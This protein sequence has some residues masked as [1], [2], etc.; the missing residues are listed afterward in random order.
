MDDSGK[1][2]ASPSGKDGDSVRI[3]THGSGG[4]GSALAYQLLA[5]VLVTGAIGYLVLAGPGRNSP[6]D[7]GTTSTTPPKTQTDAADVRG[8]AAAAITTGAGQLTP[9][10]TPP[11]RDRDDLS[12]YVAPGQA[13]TMAEVIQRLNDAGIHTGLGA[14]NPPGTSPPLIG[15]AVPDDYVMPEGYVRHFQATDDGQRI[16]PVLMYSPDYEFFDSAGRRIQIPEDRIVPVEL[17]PPG[18]PLRPIEIPPPIDP[19][20][21]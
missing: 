18:L 20:S 14:F 6:A 21:R 10:P 11:P 17:A 4:R 2:N 15:L 19:G 7:A 12:N 8:A 1:M 13:P 3:T 9:R 16:E 5:L